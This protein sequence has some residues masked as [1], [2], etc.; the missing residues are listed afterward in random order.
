V[1]SFSLYPI[2]IG[3]HILMRTNLS[4]NQFHN[5]KIY[6]A[7]VKIDIEVFNQGGLDTFYQ[8]RP[9]SQKIRW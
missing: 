8:P 2:F 3:A 5:R 1:T 7:Y 9:K 4:R 6:Y